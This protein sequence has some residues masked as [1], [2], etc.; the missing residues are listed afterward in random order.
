M[1]TFNASFQAVSDTTIWYEATA[2]YNQQTLNVQLREEVGGYQLRTT[3]VAAGAYSKETFAEILQAQLRLVSANGYFYEVVSNEIA[4]A[5]MPSNDP[6][7]PPKF[8]SSWNVTNL[9]N[10]KFTLSISE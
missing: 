5:Q 8:G 10:A 3:T 4:Y 7:A 2:Y 1:A 9:A 6:D